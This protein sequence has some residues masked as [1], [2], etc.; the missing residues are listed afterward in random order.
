MPRTS[1]QIRRDHDHARRRAPPAVHQVVDVAPCGDV[2]AARRL[3][4]DEDLGVAGQPL[5]E[6]DLLLIA[7]AQPA[8][9][10]V[11]ARGLDA[12]LVDHAPG[13]SALARGVH[14]APPGRARMFAQ[15]RCCARRTG[16]ARAPVLC[17]PRA[18][19]RCRAA[20]LRRASIPRATCPRIAIRPSSIG[21][22][23]MIAR[24]SSVRPAPTSPAMPR[25][26]PA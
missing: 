11:R 17:D 1:G 14:E 3:V 15:A 2:D 23:P 26:S 13:V 5:A 19:T 16:P 9:D 22:A 8:R 25:I 12:Q 21:S 24:A 10:P 18:G 4:E 7:A 20:R 6:H